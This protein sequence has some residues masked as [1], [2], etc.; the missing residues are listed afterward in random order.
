MTIGITLTSILEKDVFR[1][2]YGRQSQIAMNIANSALECTLFNDFQRHV[3]EALVTR[4]YDA[5]DCGELYQVRKGTD[6]SVRYSPSSDESKDSPAGTGTYQFVVIDSDREDVR[7]VSRVPCAH[8]TIK[9]ECIEGV[10]TGTNTC[11]KGLV[12]ASIEVRGYNACSSG[13]SESSRGLVR[14]FKVYY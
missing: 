5:V 8:I 11:N 9:R 1:Q 13:E 4:R 12:E 6:W 10:N 14:R 2:V 7:R 3:F